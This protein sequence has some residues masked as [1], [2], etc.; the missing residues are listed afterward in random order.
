MPRRIQLRRLAGWRKPPGAVVVARPGQWGN[1]WQVTN[2][3]RDDGLW[4]V[5][6]ESSPNPSYLT[7][8]RV[9]AIRFAVHQFSTGLTG[10]QRRRARE[11]L[12]GRDLACWCAPSQTCHADVL[13][14]IANPDDPHLAAAAL[15]RQTTGKWLDP[16]R[17][18]QLGR[19]AAQVLVDRSSTTPTWTELFATLDPA[20]TTPLHTIPAA[21]PSNQSRWRRA[22]INEAMHA[23]ARAGWVQFTREPRSLRPGAAA[24][25]Q[26]RALPQQATEP[27]TPP[28]RASSLSPAGSITAD[29]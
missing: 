29:R 12:A 3:G 18:D 9:E 28:D 6:H 4:A 14:E 1:P 10:E 2:K 5:H 21:W 13:L 8:T 11:Q 16:E 23:I 20:L 24:G 25:A 26:H 27:R 15:V 19:N 22:L 17:I 7:H